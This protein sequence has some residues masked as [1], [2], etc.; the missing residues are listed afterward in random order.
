MKKIREIKKISS[1]NKNNINKIFRGVIH[2][3]SSV[4]NTIITVTDI[5]GQVVSWTSAGTSGFRGTRKRT[6]YVVQVTACNVSN[7]I[8]NRGITQVEVFLKG[9]GIGRDVALRTIRRNGILLNLV[10]DVTPIPHNGC[11]PPKK[12]LL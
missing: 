6:P 11:R 12:R 2:I 9:P 3:Q 1:R 5:L 7:Q 8:I 10:R 4:N